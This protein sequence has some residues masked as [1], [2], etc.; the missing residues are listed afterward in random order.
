[1]L[2]YAARE[3]R[4]SGRSGSPRAL[5]LIVAGHAALITAVMTARMEIASPIKDP[6]PTLIKIPPEPLPPPPQPEPRPRVPPKAEP[7]P[8]QRFIEQPHTIIDMG[9]KDPSLV[10]LGPIIRD[11]PPATGPGLFVDPPRQVP[12][13]TGAIPRTPEHALRPPYPA[14]KLRLEEEATLRLRLRIDSAGRVTSVEPIGTADPSF[15]AAARRHIIRAWRYK[16]A[17]E[18]GVTVASTLVISLSFR[19]DDA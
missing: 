8:Q 14:D 17:T 18:D 11:I 5:I 4:I 15:L 1:M 9:R 7:A 19:L 6:V 2:A 16:P 10:D 13:R 12:V 3:R